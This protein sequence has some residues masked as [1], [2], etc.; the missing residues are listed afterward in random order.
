MKR[1]VS[2]ISSVCV[3]KLN[4]QNFTEKLVL[5]MRT[6]DTE[7]MISMKMNVSFM[8]GASVMM[9]LNVMQRIFVRQTVRQM[10]CVGP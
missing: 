2:S 6:L 5:G 9:R 10:N 8:R 1:E 7:M 3:M 4:Y